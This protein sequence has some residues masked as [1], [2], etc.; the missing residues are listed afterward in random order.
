MRL[1]NRPVTLTGP[2]DTIQIYRNQDGIPVIKA[3][4]P[5]DMAYA[6][7]LGPCQ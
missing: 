2:N 5:A 4:N 1:K 6:F 3:R 7:G